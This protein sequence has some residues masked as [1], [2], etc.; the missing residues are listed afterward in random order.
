MGQTLQMDK[1]LCQ[2]MRQMSTQEICKTPE[3]WLTPTIRST[4]RSRDLYFS[5]FHHPIT[6]SQGQTQIMVEGDGF[7]KMAPFIG[8]ATNA[9]TKEVAD[10]FLKEG[11]SG[12]C[13]S[14][15]QGGPER[16]WSTKGGC[17]PR[18]PS[19]PLRSIV[20]HTF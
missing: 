4:L 14:V 8:L 19:G 1:R 7:T 3:V 12:K 15:V 5:G 20:I 16:S 18:C 9:L 17:G 6:E 10:S 2:I 13:R 11:A